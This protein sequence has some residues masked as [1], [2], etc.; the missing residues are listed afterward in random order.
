M[1]KTIASQAATSAYFITGSDKRQL[2]SFCQK[3]FVR[4]AT[5]SLPARKRI[6]KTRRR[7]R[8]AKVLQRRQSQPRQ[9]RQLENVG[10]DGARWNGVIASQT[11]SC[12]RYPLFSHA[13][14]A[15]ARLSTDRMKRRAKRSPGAAAF[16]A[17]DAAVDEFDDAV[18]AAGEIHI[19]SDEQEARAALSEQRQVVCVGR[20]TRRPKRRLGREGAPLGQRGGA[21]LFVS[22][23][24]DEMTLLIEMVVDLGM[25]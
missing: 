24:G 12:R 7:F 8:L 21:P 2:G 4:H 5:G 19:V 6:S 17:V 11:T 16:S 23:A 14:C 20:S 15:C 3:C 1:H 13:S 9:N 25:N 22:L 10:P 18:A